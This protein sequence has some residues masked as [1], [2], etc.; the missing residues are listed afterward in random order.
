MEKFLQTLRNCFFIFG[1]LTFN[2]LFFAEK[3]KNLDFNLTVDFAFY[4]ESENID[5]GNINSEK[6]NFAPLTDFYKALECRANLEGTYTIPTPLSEHWLFNSANVKISEKLEFTPI[7]ISPITS[8]SF[9]PVPFLVFS[10][11]FQVGT[12]WN[13]GNLFKNAM[14]VYSPESDDT[15][16][17]D[18]LTPF[19]HLYSKYWLQGTF[20]FDTGAILKGDWKHIQ[21]LYTYQM[22]YQGLTGVKD[23]TIWAWQCTGNKVNGLKEYQQ[24]VLAYSMPLVLSRVGLL[25]ESDR[26]Y[27]DNVFEN[28]NY[29]AS[30]AEIDLSPMFQFTF[31]TKDTLIALLDFQ[32]R[33]K[34][35]TYKDDIPESLLDRSGREWYFRRVALKYVHKF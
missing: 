26:Y 16:N 30:F 4:P 6:V 19:S 27:K 29:E 1:F 9:T 3:P 25:F 33:R 32:G 34:F 23:K 13:I 22:Y 5:G 15:N 12:G 31:G 18:A 35:V 8:I 24:A 14:S 11:G 17:Y 21:F 28:K 20:Q 10:T 2:A 7:S